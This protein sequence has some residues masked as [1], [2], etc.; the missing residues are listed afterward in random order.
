MSDFVNVAEEKRQ[1]CHAERKSERRCSVV[2]QCGSAVERVKLETVPVGCKGQLTSQ[3]WQGG[4]VAIRRKEA[5][6][7]APVLLRIN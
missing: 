5:S 7:D 2:L 1:L 3:C 4:A 6:G